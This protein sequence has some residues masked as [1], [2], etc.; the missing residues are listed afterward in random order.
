MLWR[1]AESGK[2]EKCFNLGKITGYQSTRDNTM[3][4]GICSNSIKEI[5]SCYNRGVVKLIVSDGKYINYPN[6]SGIEGQCSP[7][8]RNDYKELL[9]CC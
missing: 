9:Q 1:L 6:A 4:G 2:I 7:R 8:Y 3:I 5:D